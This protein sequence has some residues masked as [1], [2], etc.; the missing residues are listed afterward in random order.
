MAA[1]KCMVQVSHLEMCLEIAT[2]SDHHEMSTWWNVLNQKLYISV[3]ESF[4]GS[5]L[6]GSGFEKEVPYASL[7]HCLI[8][9]NTFNLNNLFRMKF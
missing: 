5:V 1:R 3:R 7:L 9:G 4:W 8:I 2:A 6:W